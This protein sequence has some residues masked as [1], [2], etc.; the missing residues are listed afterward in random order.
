MPEPHD[1]D[2]TFEPAAETLRG[3]LRDW[4]LDNYRRLD[5]PW[6]K[7]SELE[8]RQ[9]ICRAEDASRA[10]VRGALGLAVN[11]P[12]PTIAVAVG[13]YTGKD[14][15][16]K[17]EFT[18]PDTDDNLVRVARAGRAVLVLVDPDEFAGERAPARAEPDQPGLAL[19][20]GETIDPETGEVIRAG[21]PGEPLALPP[22]RSD[23]KAG[24]GL[25]LDEAER[26]FIKARERAEKK[27]AAREAADAKAPAMPKAPAPEP[28]PA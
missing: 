2:K 10:A 6:T 23:G 18:C 4:L 3:D 15:T 25:P 28:E 11:Y 27:K 21:A 5:K 9:L 26:R 7:L 24:D 19:G 16:L 22:P 12:F 14:G 13:K 20:E 1:A 8:Q 17:A